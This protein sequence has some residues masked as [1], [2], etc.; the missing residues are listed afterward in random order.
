MRL[1]K[2]AA[3]APGRRLLEA[4][5]SDAPSVMSDQ[6]RPEGTYFD[7]PWDH[8][9]G[10]Y[11]HPLGSSLTIELHE[12]P[13]IRTVMQNAVA[14]TSEAVLTPGIQGSLFDV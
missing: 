14:T 13:D 7:E 10:F 3:R 2:S 8:E 4:A 9:Q 1:T 12:M 5:E 11:I 6:A